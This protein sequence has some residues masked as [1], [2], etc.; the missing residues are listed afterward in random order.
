MVA[1]HQARLLA[2][3]LQ[4]THHPRHILSTEDG[5]GYGGGGVPSQSGGVVHDLPEAELPAGHPPINFVPAV[6]ADRLG[7]VAQTHVD[8]ALIDPAIILGPA[9]QADGP[10]WMK[11]GSPGSAWHLDQT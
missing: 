11:V 1:V 5:G 7:E 9:P 3:A 2:G 10:L 4:A 6:I 8:I